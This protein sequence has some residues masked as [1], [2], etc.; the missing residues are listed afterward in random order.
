MTIDHII[1]LLS[2]HDIPVS[3]G[4]LEHKYQLDGGVISPERIVR[5]LNDFGLKTRQV[6]FGWK[7]LRS[8]GAAYP[9][10]A[11][12]TDGQTL[13][14]SGFNEDESN[15]EQ[16]LVSYTPDL[17]PDQSPFQFWDKASLQAV[18]SGQLI[19]IKKRRT[20]EGDA[21][22]F[23]LRW[24][25]PEITRQGRLFGEIA[26]VALF[27]HL[28]ALA[29]PLYFQTVVDKV[30]VN[31]TINTLNVMSIGIVAV[32]LAEGMFKF[33]RGYLL[34]FATAKIDMRLATRTFAKLVSLPM[35]FFER[36]LAGIVTK[37]MQQAEKIREF[38]TGNMLETVL[39]ATALF[40][41]VPILFLYSVKL[42]MVVLLF[43]VLIA[44]LIAFLL[45]PFYRRLMALYAA[46]GERQAM[47]VESIHGISTVK[48]LAL[49]PVRQKFWDRSAA[50]TV[51]TNFSV[52]K[53]ATFAQAATKTLEKGMQV[54]VVWFGAQDVIAGG[55]TVGALIAFQMLSGNVS[56]PLIRLVELAH[57]YQKI[58]LSIQML[59]EIMNRNSE[60]TGGSAA[61]TPELKGK[62]EFEDVVFRY[63]LGGRAVLDGIN[64][65]IQAGEVI[66]LVGRSGSG[67]S[68]I[69]RL[70]QGLHQAQSGLIRLDGVDMRELD[71]AHLRRSIG[72]VLQEN[73]LFHGTVRENIGIT[74]PKATFAEVVHAA[75]MAGADE[76]IQHLKQGYD[77][78][79]EE[80]GANLSGGQKQRLAIA[81]ALLKEPRVLIFDEATS[82]L[83]PESE[84]IIQQNL[85][86]I[87]K[88][89]TMIIVAHRLSTLRNADRIIVMDKGVIESI[90]SHDELLGNSLV[91][92]EL[93]SLQSRYSQ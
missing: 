52:E 9:V 71:L 7:Q 11:I 88:G 36:S 38:L 48:S 20:V 90:G 80:N 1:T 92:S 57:E 77:T 79:L 31:H 53:M 49:E 65:S 46:E 44:I 75:Q 72:V 2:H 73:F 41:F 18:W 43:S 39:D 29:L 62:I 34:S 78:I 24:F 54:A 51:T 50:N 23:G 27:M 47:L 58:H 66:G 61:L 85:E 76:F 3:R 82:A 22:N 86:K 4:Q 93:W 56:T 19:L 70:I 84:Y 45:S 17:P 12:L 10:L 64:F 6:R 60:K 83:D 35:S 63:E 33:L 8:M 37:H 30:L 59:G 21:Q 67:K 74:N 13:V 89:R 68:T 32:I 28:L 5:I 81:R 91:Y 26:L 40:V 42:S 16:H 87:A 69:T 14:F 25:L 15:G 55:M